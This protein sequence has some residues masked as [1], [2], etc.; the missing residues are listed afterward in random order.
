MKLKTILA[1]VAL[2]WILFAQMY[3]VCLAAHTTASLSRLESNYAFAPSSD[4]KNALD[5]EFERVARYESHRAIARFAALLALDVA[6]IALFWNFGA[7][8][9]PLAEP[10]AVPANLPGRLNAS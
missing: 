6:L 1:R 9:K 5:N 3:Y 2:V 10:S 8:R 4:H 7:K